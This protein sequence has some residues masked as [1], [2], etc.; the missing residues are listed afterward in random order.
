MCYFYDYYYYYLTAIGLT[1]GVSTDFRKTRQYQISLK[2]AHWQPSCSMVTD[3][4]TDRYDKANSRFSQF[5]ER[6]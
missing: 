5:C 1:P 4:Q 6:A 3:G 2:S